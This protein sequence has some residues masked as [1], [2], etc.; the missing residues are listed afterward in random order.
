MAH[1]TSRWPAL[2]HCFQGSGD[3]LG[4]IQFSNLR[5]IFQ[6]PSSLFWDILYNWLFPV[7]KPP[8]F[9]FFLASQKPLCFCPLLPQLLLL[10]LSLDSLL[11]SPKTWCC[12]ESALHL[13]LFLWDNGL[14]SL[15]MPLIQ[16]AH[17]WLLNLSLLRASLLQYSS[18]MPYSVSQNLMLFFLHLPHSISFKRI[19][20]IYTF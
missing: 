7:L 10:S 15:S 19:I 13:S 11:L 20:I 5:N 12:S 8:P 2:Q 16:E 14:L 17:W 3:C 6:S 1:E 18:Y 9:F 4:Q